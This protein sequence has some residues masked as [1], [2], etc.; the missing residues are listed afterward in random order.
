MKLEKNESDIVYNWLIDLKKKSVDPVTRAS[1]IKKYQLSKGLSQRA[2]AKELNIPHSTLQDWLMWDKLDS[3]DY[4]KMK[5]SGY[6]QKM[7]YRALRD[8]KGWDKQLIIDRPTLNVELEEFLRRIG[9]YERK[10]PNDIETATLISKVKDQ[11]NRILMYMEK[12][13]K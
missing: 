12:K 3:K 13:D 11:L 5:N 4:D 2:L 1:I 6:N 10:T 7:V 8:H 9:K